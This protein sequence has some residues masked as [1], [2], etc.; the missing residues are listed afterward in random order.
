MINV[1]FI[2]ITFFLGVV[3]ALTA[4][5]YHL[6]TGKI[7]SDQKIS[8]NEL[9]DKI[10]IKINDMEE[11]IEKKVDKKFEDLKNDIEKKHQHL[12]NN[13][14]HVENLAKLTEK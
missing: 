8:S 3:S 1:P 6:F 12:L 10:E 2:F 4:V 5:I 7:K 9:K 14:K 13:I 11:K